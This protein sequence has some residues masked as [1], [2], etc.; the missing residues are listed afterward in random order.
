MTSENA[1]LRRCKLRE[2]VQL[3]FFNIS[4][5]RALLKDALTDKKSTSV[6]LSE[7]LNQCS[8]G[9]HQIYSGR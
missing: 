4:L 3:S 7:G 8:V 2:L 9:H 1:G 6:I 5:T